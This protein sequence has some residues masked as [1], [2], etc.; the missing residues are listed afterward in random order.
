MA[1]TSGC[2]KSKRSQSGC[3]CECNGYLHGIPYFNHSGY[4]EYEIFNEIHEIHK[5]DNSSFKDEIKNKIK[6]ISEKIKNDKGN[7]DKFKNLKSSDGLEYKDLQSRYSRGIISKTYLCIYSEIKSSS[8]DG[9]FKSEKI[10]KE[11]FQKEIINKLSNELSDKIADEILGNISLGDDEKRKDV[12]GY[13]HKILY[14][15]LIC[16]L[17]IYILEAINKIE[18]KLCECIEYIASKSASSIKDYIIS[19]I[20][21]KYKEKYNVKLSKRLERDIENILKESIEKSLK[22][23]IKINLLPEEQID[24]FCIV[25]VISCPDIADHPE[26]INY[27]AN[28]LLKKYLK[29]IL[30]DKIRGEMDKCL[31]D[32]Q[33]IEDLGKYIGHF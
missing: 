23:I 15:H 16:T 27:C 1:H 3:R 6:H 14:S 8:I 12:K 17:C 31:N 2:S 11:D 24:I 18:K 13:I 22:K 21:E 5:T 9:F 30:Q 7:L 29:P 33:R 28:P 4:K 19:K 32:P 25:G 20:K 26:I 10:L